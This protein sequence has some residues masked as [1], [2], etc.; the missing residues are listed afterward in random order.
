MPLAG[1]RGELPGNSQREILH[2]DEEAHEEKVCSEE[3]GNNGVIEVWKGGEKM[4]TDNP[5]QDYKR[6]LCSFF[7]S[8]RACWGRIEDTFNRAL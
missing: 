5:R 6:N 8:C 2:E 4:R 7:G 1:Q 3:E